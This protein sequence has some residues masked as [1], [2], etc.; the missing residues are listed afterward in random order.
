MQVRYLY[1][2]CPQGLPLEF[3]SVLEAF[4]KVW[5]K[6]KNRR[7][8]VIH[9]RP[10]WDSGDNSHSM[11]EH[12][13]FPCS[14]KDFQFLGVSIS[15]LAGP[16]WEEFAYRL[17]DEW[18]MVA[19]KIMDSWRTYN[20]KRGDVFIGFRTA[21]IDSLSPWSFTIL[22]SAKYSNGLDCTYGVQFSGG[23]V[24]DIFVGH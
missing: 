21:L 1:L 12:D 10:Y 9:K 23:E 8:V 15:L 17:D 14:G 11:D 7:T 6:A 5:L 2:R 18:P 24:V 20:E 16:D 13:V 4:D 3:R 22:C 19:S